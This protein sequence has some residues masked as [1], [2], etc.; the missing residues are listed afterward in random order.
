MIF[1]VDMDKNAKKS[2]RRKKRS[3]QE[4]E[5]EQDENFS[6]IV[7]YTS[8]GFPYGNPWEELDDEQDDEEDVFI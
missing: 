5:L 7:G 8:G 2:K 4:F 1:E 6:F 3:I